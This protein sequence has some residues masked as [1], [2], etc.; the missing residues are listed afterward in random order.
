M[1]VDAFEINEE[2]YNIKGIDIKSN[3]WDK[4]FDITYSYYH[5]NDI[6]EYYLDD[7]LTLNRY[8]FS[9][10]LL[11]DSNV[12]I[13]CYIEGLKYMDSY[14]MDVEDISTLIERFNNS[15]NFEKIK[16]KSKVK[17]NLSQNKIIDL[18]SYRNN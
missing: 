4:L 5:D 7:M 3:D 6:E 15:R 16:Q 17:S 1:I 12:D 11:N 2:I 13:D 10:A 9:L 8:A 18:N 14:Y